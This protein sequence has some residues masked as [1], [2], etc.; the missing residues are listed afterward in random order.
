MPSKPLAVPVR[1]QALRALIAW[2]LLTWLPQALPAAAA[3]DGLKAGEY[4]W[5]PELAPGGPLVIV[6]S[7]PEQRAR[8]YRNGIRIGVTTISSGRRGYETPP[9]VY[10]ILQKRREHYSNL[11]DDAPMPY[12][13]RLTWDGVALHGGQVTGKPAS[14]GCVRLPEAFAEKLF[15]VT[16]R[17]MTVIVAEGAA[18][19]PNLERSGILAPTE[20]AGAAPRP[21]RYSPPQRY[22]LSP[23]LATSG[24]ISVLISSAD[25][26]VVVLRGG[27]EIARARIDIEP[28]VHFGLHAWVMLE[29]DAGQPS[30]V[31]P[32]RREHQWMELALPAHAPVGHRPFDAAAVN[33]FRLPPPFLATIHDWLEP[34][35]TVIVTDEPVDPGSKVTVLDAAEERKG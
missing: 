19:V 23:G 6:V 21:R 12:M 5:T 30:A 4:W 29:G 13:Q 24:P 25:A 32:G 14:H 16:E 28:G 2:M 31:V 8:V 9:G 34:G 27:S 3:D 33:A 11:Y 1:R 18:P 15:E 10:A 17:G 35:A 20:A 7:L 22:H 26:A